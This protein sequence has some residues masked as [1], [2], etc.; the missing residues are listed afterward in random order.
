M[1]NEEMYEEEDDDLPLQYRRLTAH[2]Q[3]G[4]ADFNRRLAAYLTNQV[5]V[6]SAL[7]QAIT[8]SY[9]QQYPNAPQFAHNQPG[10]FPSPLMTQGLGY[11]LQPQQE[12]PR[13]PHPYRQSP[14]P[15]AGMPNHRN[16][17]HQ[18]SSSIATT[19]VP[20]GEPQS[21]IKSPMDPPKSNNSRRMSMPA[22][23]LS[24][25]EGQAMLSPHDVHSMMS[26]PA[27]HVLSSPHLKDEQKSPPTQSSAPTSSSEHRD[28]S[29]QYSISPLT[30]SLPQ[31]SQ[32]LLGSAMIP[33][34]AF[35]NMLMSGTPTIGSMFYGQNPY[36]M[37]SK[38]EDY[39]PSF[40]GM[41]STLAPS[42]LDGT[43]ILPTTTDSSTSLQGTAHDNEFNIPFGDQKGI[44]FSCSQNSNSFS[45][46]NWDAFINDNSWSENGT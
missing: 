25:G 27:Q 13:S 2:L 39:Y 8:N 41:N 15:T 10:M 17:A 36:H 16:I 44:E 43:A 29:T 20:A 6:R 18:R 40:D 31:D 14:Y 42:A 19:P 9:A 22:S 45:D 38:Q 28:A 24:K 30:M 46:G 12:S 7:D 33:N 5:A 37:M 3:T 1:V 32:M 26:S 34:D 11:P 23:A 35:T 4:S 21:L